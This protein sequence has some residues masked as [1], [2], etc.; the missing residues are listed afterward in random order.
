MDKQEKPNLG[1]DCS[2]KKKRKKLLSTSKYGAINNIDK[3]KKLER[4]TDHL[5]VDIFDGAV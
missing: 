3:K 1:R 2:A 4:L 5:Y